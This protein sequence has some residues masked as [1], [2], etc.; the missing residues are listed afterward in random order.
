MSK[1]KYT[2]KCREISGIGGGYEEACRKMVIS[3]MEW[4]ENHKNATPKFDQFKNIYG[5]TANENEDMQKMQS[6][7][8][9]AI[10]DG[11]T[12]AMMQCCTNHVLFANKNGWEKYILEMEKVS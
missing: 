5:F 3:G 11:A 10:N 9:E 2:E 6:A 7:M 12:G 1:Y 8:N 4:L